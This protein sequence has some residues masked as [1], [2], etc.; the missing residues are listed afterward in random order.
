M[1]AHGVQ[2]QAKDIF[3]HHFVE[4]TFE[5]VAKTVKLQIEHIVAL[6]GKRACKFLR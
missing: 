2:T 4:G 3:S 5:A 6:Y 1:E